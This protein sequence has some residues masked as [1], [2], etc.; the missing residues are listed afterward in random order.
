MKKILAIVISS[1]LALSVFGQLNSG[2]Y[3]FKSGDPN[4]HWQEFWNYG[5]LKYQD[6]VF[7]VSI[8]GIGWDIESIQFNKREEV[9]KDGYW[10][11]VN[12]NGVDENYD[13]PTG[14]YEFQTDQCNYSFDEPQ[15]GRIILHRFDCVERCDNQT[16]GLTQIRR[17]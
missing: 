5:A 16:I 14:W 11:T 4:F 9:L 7:T 17:Y 1:C 3:V 13:G 2:T 15:N 8:G 10:R 6:F 12:M